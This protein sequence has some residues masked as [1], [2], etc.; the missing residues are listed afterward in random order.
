[1]M[2]GKLPKFGNLGPAKT[3]NLAD[4]KFRNLRSLGPAKLPK[5]GHLKFVKLAN[6]RSADE[7][8]A[9]NPPLAVAGER[10]EGPRRLALPEVREHEATGSASS[11]RRE[12]RWWALESILTLC[13]SCHIDHH[14]AERR[15]TIDPAIAAWRNALE[16][17]RT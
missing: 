8:E 12:A 2:A 6:L 11:D 10:G 13:A 9:P 5:L 3:A 7:R 17:L 14:R 16:E 1:M 15:R 4:L